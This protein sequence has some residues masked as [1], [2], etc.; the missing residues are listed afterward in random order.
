M[1]YGGVFCVSGDDIKSLFTTNLRRIFLH[2]LF[3]RN[4][5]GDQQKKGAWTSM[6]YIGFGPYK[7]VAVI[8]AFQ[9]LCW[10]YSGFYIS[11]QLS[12]V[13]SKSF[14]AGEMQSHCTTV[15][16]SVFNIM[17]DC[18]LQAELTSLSARSLHLP[19]A[20]SAIYVEYDG[21]GSCFTD[22]GSVGLFTLPG[23][24]Q[25]NRPMIATILTLKNCT[26]RQKWH[27]IHR[28]IMH[29]CVFGTTCGCQSCQIED[30]SW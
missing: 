12:T 21:V 3:K 5:N 25:P 29:L 14:F 9:K 7:S 16:L 28:L 10:N 4:K 17:F 11:Q 27:H 1:V 13:A 19:S 20:L 6:C 18:T 23:N 2:I 26:A 24:T 15:L 22:A 30:R 8:L